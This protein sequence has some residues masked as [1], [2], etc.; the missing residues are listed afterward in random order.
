MHGLASVQDRLQSL[1]LVSIYLYM[2]GLHVWGILGQ[3]WGNPNFDSLLRKF[4]TTRLKTYDPIY[5]RNRP[6]P[7]CCIYVTLT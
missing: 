4:G 1:P 3:R 6:Y 7:G 2:P 5:F